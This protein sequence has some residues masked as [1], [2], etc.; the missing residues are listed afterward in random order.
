MGNPTNATYS[1]F[2][3]KAQW[4]RSYDW[5]RYTPE[6]HE[7]W[8]KSLH[9]K[10]TPYTEDLKRGV[11]NKIEMILTPASAD[12]LQ[13]LVISIDSKSVVLNSLP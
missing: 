2:T 7:K 6:S 8:E 13:Y 12:E 1:N 4:G 3:I 10:E 5:D 9:S 11:W